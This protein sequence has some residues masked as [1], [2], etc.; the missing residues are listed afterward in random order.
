MCKKVGVERENLSGWL[1]EPDQVSRGGI[2]LTHGAGGNC[3]SRLLVAMA[4]AFCAHGW[5]VL[6]YNLPFRRNRPYGPPL[7]HSA[8]ADQNGI[9]DAIRHLRNLTNGPVVAAGH[10][11]GGRQTTMLA[12]KEPSLC[13]AIAAFSYPLHP[14]KKPDQLRMAHFAELRVPVLFVHGSND[15][16]GSVPEMQSAIEVIA[17][18]TKL[19][20]VQGGGHDL[21][22]GKFD[23]EGMVVQE[24]SRLVL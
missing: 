16:F 18:E 13:D 4:E 6:R 9:G 2:A 12:A 17:C 14:P 21:K 19:V 7:P 3:D 10:S 20:I 5:T 1:H 15:P 11:Y 24:I 23:V 22:S 8:A